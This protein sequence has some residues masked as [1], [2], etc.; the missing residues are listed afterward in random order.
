LPLYGHRN[1]IVIAD[2]AYPAQSSP[3]IETIATG[4]GQ[5]EVVEEVLG[6]VAAS[7]HVR[8]VVYSDRELEF[9]AEADAPGADAYRARL[10]GL[11]HH[12][13]CRTLPHEEIISMLDQAGAAFRILVLKTA[14]AIPYTS[15]FVNLDCAYWTAAAER[16]LRASMARQPAPFAGFR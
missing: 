9:V 6:A 11:T 15:V 12:L 4:A 3:G 8:P 14:L 13:D 5:L 2:A 1:W 10:A 7:P 16:R